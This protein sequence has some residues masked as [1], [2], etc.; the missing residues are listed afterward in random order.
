[1]I[2]KTLPNKFPMKCTQNIVTLNMC[3]KLLVLTW[4]PGQFVK[5]FSNGPGKEAKNMCMHGGIACLNLNV[6]TPT[7][8]SRRIGEVAGTTFSAASIYDS[9]AGITMF[10]KWRK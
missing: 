9:T 8:L 4:F 7:H 10:C 5:S 6:A 3:Y 1:M 2:E